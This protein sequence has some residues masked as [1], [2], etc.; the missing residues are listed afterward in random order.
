VT[1]HT[2][3]RFRFERGIRLL[4]QS[5]VNIDKET[6][7]LDLG[8]HQGQFLR[9]L[10]DKF[11][12]HPIGSDD[13]KPELKSE[14]D[15]GWQYLQ[16]DFEQSI[17]DCGPVDI[18]SA[19]EVLEHVTDTDK[20]LKQIHALLK[21]GGWVLIS[22]PNINSLRNRITVP[23]GIYPTGLEF[24]NVIHHV[25]LYNPAVLRQQL[26]E[27]GYHN[28]AVWGVSFLPFSLNLGTSRMSQALA[29]QFPSLCNNFLVVARKR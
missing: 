22:T 6:E 2:L 15:S 4:Q 28:I 27:I 12:L 7:W 3:D 9:L 25:R 11:S 16:A 23:F 20:F 13:W 24:R 19:L 29:N 14:G 10:I 8:C 17:P 1:V 5:G 26:N 21:P 18:V